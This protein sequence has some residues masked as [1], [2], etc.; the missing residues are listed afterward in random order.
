MRDPITE[1]R[2]EREGVQ[3]SY[4]EAIPLA[5]ID[6]QGSLRNQARLIPIDKPTVERYALKMIDGEQFPPVILEPVNGGLYR[7]IDGNHRVAAAT[8]AERSTVDAYLVADLDALTRL[9]LVH[10]WNI[11]NGR[12]PSREEII[13]HALYLCD[14]TPY[15][16]REVAKM[17]GMNERTLGGH[18]RSRKVKDRLF[19]LGV[20]AEALGPAHAECLYPISDD[21]VLAE[22]TRLAIRTA[23]PAEKLR[24]LVADVERARNEPDRLAV[25]KGWATR[26]KDRAAQS[27]GGRFTTPQRRANVTKMLGALNTVS[28]LCGR[29]PS[30]MGF[31]LTLAED[32]EAIRGAYTEATNRLRRLLDSAS[33]TQGAA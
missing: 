28:R 29:D 10:T 31:G 27:G 4:A 7:A 33:R 20:P 12:Q 9:R 25:V 19:G 3:H 14:N 6:V 13:E 23:L 32:V 2:L 18:V 21:S 8:E 11:G 16:Q 22:V 1:S 24:T 5:A 26:L 30:A 15:S 17:V